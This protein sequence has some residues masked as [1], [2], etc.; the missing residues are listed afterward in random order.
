M[1]GLLQEGVEA[2]VEAGPPSSTT[3]DT[4]VIIPMLKHSR[5]MRRV[6]SIVP[7]VFIPL[8]LG[9]GICTDVVELRSFFFLDIQRPKLGT[10]RV[11][12]VGTGHFHMSK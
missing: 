12:H 1:F 2:P 6:S 9:F 10:E 4:I 11:F 5:R 8:P 7:T 3:F